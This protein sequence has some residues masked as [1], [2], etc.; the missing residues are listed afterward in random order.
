MVGCDAGEMNEGEQTIVFDG[1]L[2]D[3]HH[4]DERAVSFWWG[5]WFLEG[6]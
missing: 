1:E 6:R 3:R 4:G 5:S 2:G